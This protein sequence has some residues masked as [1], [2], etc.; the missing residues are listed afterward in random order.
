M[1]KESAVYAEH[2]L[3]LF[4][5]I[6]HKT[7][8]LQPLREVAADITPSLAQYLQFLFRH[9]T[10][11]VRDIAQGLS[12]TYSAIS[13][14]TERL[15]KKEMVTRSENK[16]DRRLSEIQLTDKGHD[17][18]EQIRLHRMSVM[19]R[20]LDRIDHSNRKALIENLESFI[21]AAVDSEKL[22]LETCSHCGTDH[23]SDCVINEV[24]RAAT[25]TSINQ[26]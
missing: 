21:T 15:V 19:S 4:T 9:G 17:L 6:L 1:E 5:E 14:L 18:I 8:T 24:Y 13:Q 26:V 12:I 22:A 23:T 25:G 2:V 10:C 3:D 7:I 16:R 20:I 11:S